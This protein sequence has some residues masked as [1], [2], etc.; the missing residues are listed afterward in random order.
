MGQLLVSHGTRPIS[1]MQTLFRLLILTFS[2]RGQYYLHNQG[3]LTNLTYLTI[4]LVMELG[5]NK[6]KS[7]DMPHLLLEYSAQGCPERYC[8]SHERTMEERRAVIGC[9]V[10]TSV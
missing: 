1:L 9:F 8:Q 10:I 3:F 7:K 4:A 2:P 5:L 6:A